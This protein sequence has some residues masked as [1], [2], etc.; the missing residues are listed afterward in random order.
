[1]ET[2][3]TAKLPPNPKNGTMASYGDDSAIM[4]TF[5]DDF[6]INEFRTEQEGKTIYDHFICIR[7]EYP[8]NNLSDFRY[9]FRPEEGVKGNRWT[10]RFAGQWKAFQAQKE[11]LPEGT[12]IELWPLLDKKRVLEFKAM[13]L[14]TIEQIA[15]LTD[16]TGPNMGLD[17]RKLRDMATAYLNPAISQVTIS[18]LNHE[19]NDL[20]NRLQVLENQLSSIA[21][22]SASVPLADP[23]KRR[24]RPPRQEITIQE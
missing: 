24:G 18:K 14:H 6:V 23:P 1:M 12:P 2:L 20:K 5:D 3:A 10:E 22:N 21:T 8:G 16:Q 13:R 17:W 7:L 11:Q 4:A 9:R 19:N 15:A